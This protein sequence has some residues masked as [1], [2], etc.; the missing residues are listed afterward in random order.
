MKTSELAG[1]A[2]DALV[3]K[4][5]NEQPGTAYTKSWPDFDALIEREAIHVAPLVGKGFAWC[6]I[7]VGRPGGRLPESRGTWKE[8]QTMRIAVARA[9]VAAKFGE[10]V[11]VDG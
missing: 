10:E 3:A 6:A 7:V 2:L 11:D 8:G 1:P 9:I 5:V 4:A